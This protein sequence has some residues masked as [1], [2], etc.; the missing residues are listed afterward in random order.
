[1]K[2]I[3]TGGTGFIGIRLAQKLA[4]IGELS[5]ATGGTPSDR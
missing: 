4:R 1:M 2:V 3:I 5:S